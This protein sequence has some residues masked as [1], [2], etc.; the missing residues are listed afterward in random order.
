MGGAADEQ[1][2]RS[3]SRCR[4]SVGSATAAAAALPCYMPASLPRCR[5][6]MLLPRHMLR[7]VTWEP[8]SEGELA[9]W[10]LHGSA[11]IGLAF[12]E[13]DAL[14]RCT[15]ATSH[16]PS[17]VAP[18]GAAAAGPPPAAAPPSHG[19]RHGCCPPHGAAGQ[20][21]ARGAAAGRRCRQPSACAAPR[22]GRIPR[23]AGGCAPADLLGAA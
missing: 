15:A 9:E 8:E 21:W 12:E 19:V 13:E 4:F 5:L 3:C 1:S 20:P 22:G 18:R 2:S 7:S 11:G 17:G 14:L 23:C 6:L 16:Q 10:E